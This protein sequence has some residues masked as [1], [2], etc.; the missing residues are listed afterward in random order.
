MKGIYSISCIATGQ[1]YIG[2]AKDIKRRLK[3]HRCKLER[4]RHPNYKLQDLWDRF[5]P[6]LMVFSLLEEVKGICSVEW[7]TVREQYWIDYFKPLIL[8]ISPY[9]DSFRYVTERKL[10]A[11]SKLNLQGC[12]E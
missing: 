11:K 4:G 5:G 10:N 1:R 12:R 3:E 2:Q 9:A 6:N 8:N 7:L